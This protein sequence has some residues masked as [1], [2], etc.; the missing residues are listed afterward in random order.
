MFSKAGAGFVTNKKLFVVFCNK[1]Y[2]LSVLLFH[3][4]SSV[5]EDELLRQ[6]SGGWIA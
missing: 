2:R 3:V 4:M 6:L 5:T 1:T